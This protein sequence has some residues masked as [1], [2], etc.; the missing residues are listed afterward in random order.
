MPGAKRIERVERIDEA[1]LSL[2]GGAGSRRGTGGM[3]TKLQAAQLAAAQG[4]DTYVTNGRRP[5]GL[6]DIVRGG[7][8]GT[9]FCG[10]K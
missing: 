5:E 2:A 1:V 7:S 4:I 9:L 10:Q 3:R 8:V 6:Y